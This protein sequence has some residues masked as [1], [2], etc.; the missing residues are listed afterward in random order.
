MFENTKFIS[1]AVMVGWIGSCASIVMPIMICFGIINERLSGPWVTIL[2][3]LVEIVA[4]ICGI[5]IVSRRP[6]GFLFIFASLLS[7]LFATSY[8]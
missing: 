4:L 1:Y 5:I 8:Y 6:L 7:F 2:L 3:L